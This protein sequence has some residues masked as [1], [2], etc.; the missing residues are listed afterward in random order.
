MVGKQSFVDISRL[1]SIYSRESKAPGYSFLHCLGRT[2]LVALPLIVWFHFMWYS[3]LCQECA[4][5]K[6]LFCLF[7]HF[8]VTALPDWRHNRLDMLYTNTYFK[9]SACTD[10]HIKNHTRMRTRAIT[11][12]L[13]MSLFPEFCSDVLL[14]YIN[15]TFIWGM[16]KNASQTARHSWYRK[17][18]ELLQRFNKRWYKLGTI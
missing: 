17:C 5:H 11:K 2:G 18:L 7:F 15:I 4:S 9:L 6:L 16:V 1:P 12:Y 8:K 10:F 14:S 3:Q 13:Q